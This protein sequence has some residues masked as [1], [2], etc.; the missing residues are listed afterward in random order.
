MNE[1]I[2]TYLLNVYW[3]YM[4]LAMSDANSAF[5]LSL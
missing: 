2:N 3:G 4:G 5:L 1:T